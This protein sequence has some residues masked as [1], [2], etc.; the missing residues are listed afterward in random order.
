MSDRLK[1]FLVVLHFI[2]ACILVVAFILGEGSVGDGVS[3]FAGFWAL[4]GTVLLIVIS[5]GAGD[6]LGFWAGLIM[7]GLSIFASVTGNNDL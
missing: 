3:G 6:M 7:L 1:Y 4:A 2:G 5:A